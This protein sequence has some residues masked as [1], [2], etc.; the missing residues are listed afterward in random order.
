[1]IRRYSN[2]FLIV[3]IVILASVALIYQRFDTEDHQVAI[4]DGQEYRIGETI[5]SGEEFQQVTFGSATIWLDQHTEVKIID[6]RVGQETVNVIQGRAVIAGPLNI[7]T[8]D[9]TTHIDGTASFVH[10]SWENR[11]EVAT[12]DGS[13]QI[14]YQDEDVSVQDAISLQTLPP[15][16]RNDISFSPDTSS[17]STFYEYALNQKADLN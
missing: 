4:G 14:A 13:T 2:T 8:R 15:Y 3:A 5:S 9:V 12:I 17:A 6:G 10:Y 11:I 7:K 16:E 1:M